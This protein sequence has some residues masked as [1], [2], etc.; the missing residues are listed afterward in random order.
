VRLSLTLEGFPNRDCSRCNAKDVVTL[1]FTVI[2]EEHS[3]EAAELCL[4]CVCKGGSTDIPMAMLAE[5]PSKRK[6]F[7]KI[8]KVSLKQEVEVNELLGAR[9]QPGSGN[10][11]G[12]KGD[13]RRVGDIRTEQKFTVAESFSLKLEELWKIAS[14]AHHGEMPVFVIDYKE[15]GTSKLRDRFVVLPFN[16]VMELLELRRREK[17]AAHKHR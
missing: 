16:D 2:T 6:A 15:P 5:K 17:N 13:G 7:R 1:A 11:R 10:Q 9:T 8:K 14:E 12:A 4:E 3:G